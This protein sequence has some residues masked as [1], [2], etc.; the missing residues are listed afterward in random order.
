MPTTIIGIDCATQAKRIGLALGGDD[1]A[2]AAIT[3]VL[4]GSMVDAVAET[5]AA[6]TTP[7]EPTLLALDAPLGWPAGLGRELYQH[8]AGA[9]LQGE[10]NHLFRRHTDRVI[11]RTT[12][13]LPLDV[14]AD[15]IARTAHAALALLQA[16]RQR[17]GQPIPLAWHPELN[18]GLQA[19]EVYPAGTLA[20]YGVDARGYKKREG[21]AQR[22]ALLRFLAQQ[23]SLP[24]DCALMEDNDDALDAAL[25]VLAGLD[26]LRG[27]AMEPDD[28]H[29][30]RKE[31][32]IWVR[33]SV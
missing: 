27:R 29:A 32:W 21:R 11:K 12:G 10:A 24:Q 13:K 17:T 9:P 18:S 8:Q 7:G 4:L 2:T 6:W 20:A 14:G 28:L 1:G 23:L 26:F 25:C 3:Q 33:T 22:Q 30:T 15:R 16:L 5:I 19:I 31:G